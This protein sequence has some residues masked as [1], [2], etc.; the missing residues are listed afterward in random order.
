MENTNQ[1]QEHNIHEFF[2]KIIFE[3]DQKISLLENELKNGTKVK[4]IVDPIFEQKYAEAEQENRTLRRQLAAV[5]AENT[6]TVVASTYVTDLERTK[7][8]LLASQN[9]LKTLETTLASLQH[10]FSDTVEIEQRENQILRHKLIQLSSQN[11]VVTEVKIDETKVKS[12]QS[13]LETLK[14]ESSAQIKNLE[15]NLSQV[16]KE[17]NSQLNSFKENQNNLN[18]TNM[19]M[20]N[21]YQTLR[22]QKGGFGFTSL[23]I[24]GFVGTLLGFG[25]HKIFFSP[26]DDHAQVFQ[27]FKDENLF[28]MEFDISQG[29][30][31]NVESMLKTKAATKE[32]SSIAY[33]LEFFRK[34][35]GASKRKLGDG[36]TPTEA[37]GVSGFALDPKVDEAKIQEKAKNSLTINEN[38]SVEITIRS[39]ASTGGEKLGKM[40][41]GDKAGVWDRTNGLDKI[42]ITKDGNKYEVSDYWYKVETSDGIEGWV[43]GYFTT[44]TLNRMKMIGEPVAAIPVGT[45]PAVPGANPT[46]PSTPVKIPAL[47]TPPANKGN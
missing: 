41:K 25:V 14:K 4:T 10:N 18:E 46:A 39:E 43:F 3:R 36:K 32:Y 35:I 7:S 2:K 21:D 24:S 15:E 42:T 13:E 12:L 19:R 16:K 28:N 9:E 22:K 1:E 37:A 17:S 33:E 27:K 31:E 20:R 38:A 29:R 47:E 44:K 23:L 34:I 11:T 6:S 26:K 45:T 8:E 5:K 40:K 30:F